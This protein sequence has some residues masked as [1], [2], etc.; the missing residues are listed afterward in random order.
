MRDMLFIVDRQADGKDTEVIGTLS[1]SGHWTGNRNLEEDV[2]ETIRAH[3]LD[4]TNDDHRIKLREVFSS[5]RLYAVEGQ[6][7]QR[8]I[9]PT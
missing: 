4:L 6:T 3:K 7:Y 8:A 5:S 9:P 2:R 1:E